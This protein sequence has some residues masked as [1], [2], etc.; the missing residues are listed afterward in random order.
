[1]ATI[2]TTVSTYADV[3]KRM[4]DGGKTSGILEILNKTNA[5]LDDMLVKECN[6]GTGEKT[7]VR[8]GIPQATWRL[9]NYGV[10]RVK[11]Q[12]AAVRDTTGMLEVYSEIDK[13]LADLS[14]NASQYRLSEAS[15]IMEGMSQQMASTVFYGN[16][17][18]NPER[19]TGLAPRYATGVVANAASASN[20]FD[21]GG[22]DPTSNTSAW[23]VTWGEQAT[24]GI[25]PKGSQAGLR[26]RDL[27]E[28]T[29]LDNNTP[30]QGQYQ[31]YRDHFKW[32]LGLTV[33]D[34]RTNARVAN[35]DTDQLDDP[36]YLVS[37]I[38]LMIDASEALPIDNEDT[39]A[40]GGRRVWYVN[41]TVRSAMRWAVLEKIANNLTW[42]TWMGKRVVM[43]DGTPM[44]RVDALLNTEAVVP[45]P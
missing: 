38:K 43:F 18:V 42:E 14:G 26:H 13:D 24:H 36:D 45:F 3:A 20:V 30:T 21:A 22:T 29:L 35:I 15:G 8:T 32:D 4:D 9:L 44:R 41:K 12:T 2:A 11:T 27:G 33:R 40:S 10:P 5:V 37:L 16:T 31:G 34:W 19:F 17:L 39:N 28:V 7:T 1:M 25:Y 23:L 6:D